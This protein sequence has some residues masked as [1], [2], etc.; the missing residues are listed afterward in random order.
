M[1]SIFCLMLLAWVM[2]ESIVDM[3]HRSSRGL[4]NTKRAKGL[5]YLAYLALKSMYDGTEISRYLRTEL[6]MKKL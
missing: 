4:G 6:E 2:S 5:W 1:T 3:I